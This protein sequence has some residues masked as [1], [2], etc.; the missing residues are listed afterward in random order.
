MTS[1][2]ETR[3][4]RVIWEGDHKNAIRCVVTRVE[5]TVWIVEMWQRPRFG[6][7]YVKTQGRSLHNAFWAANA[8]VRAGWKPK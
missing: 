4:S 7:P 6:C 1:V 5:G 3:I 8:A 2:Q